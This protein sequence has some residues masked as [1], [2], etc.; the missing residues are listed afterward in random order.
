MLAGESAAAEI[1][2]IT[3][4]KGAD[5]TLDF[6]GVDA[7]LLLA[8][9]VARPMSDVVLVG[10]GM[11]SF[12]F[13]FFTTPYEVSFQSTYWGSVSE[14]H[15]VVALGEAGKIRARV[16]RYSLDDA[17]QAYTDMAAG[18]LHGRVVIVP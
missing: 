6:V 12:P 3:K 2:D 1:R 13:S 5:L 10:V 16:E 7:T 14:L 9:A 4:G 18:T 17:L 15:E 11:G 8:A